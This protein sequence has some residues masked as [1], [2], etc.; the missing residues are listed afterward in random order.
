M[1]LPTRL[2]LVSV[3]HKDLFLKGLARL[4]TISRLWFDNTP[5]RKFV[6]GSHQFKNL[7]TERRTLDRVS[8]I[9]LWVLRPYQS[10]KASLLVESLRYEKYS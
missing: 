4:D 10:G 1:S 5:I 3:I 7:L 9:W 2:D 8:L 6:K